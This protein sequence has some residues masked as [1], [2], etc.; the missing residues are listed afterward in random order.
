LKP[1]FFILPIQGGLHSFPYTPV[2]GD[3]IWECP[4]CGYGIAPIN[5]DIILDGHNRFEI[6][7]RL[8]IPYKTTAIELPNRDAAADWI[9]KN[10]LGRRNLTPDQMNLLRGRRYNRVKKAHGGQVPGSRID[11]NAPSSTAAHLAKEYGVSP[12]TIKRDAKFAREVEQ[13]PELQKAIQERRPISKVKKEMKAKADRVSLEKAQKTI[14]VE[15]KK[16]LESVCDIR[17]CSC[18]DLF[19]S[20]IKP[21][22]VITDPP[23]PKEFLGAFSELA[24]SCKLAKVPLVAVMSGQAHLPEVLRMALFFPTP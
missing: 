5:D 7:E 11:Q 17:V 4:K 19:R 13:S 16:K 9:D 21:D 20:G 24:E 3:G 10:Q 15:A 12:M 2:C 18:V 23:Y 8:K 22:A 6:C 14:T 1:P